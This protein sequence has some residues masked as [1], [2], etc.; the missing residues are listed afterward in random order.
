ML[1]ADAGWLYPKKKPPGVRVLDRL[2]FNIAGQALGAANG[3]FP[4]NACSPDRRSG[5]QVYR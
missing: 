1:R 5:E 2:D 3:F 4:L